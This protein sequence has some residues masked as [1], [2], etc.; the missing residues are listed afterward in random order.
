MIRIA[1]LGSWFKVQD[2]E[3]WFMVLCRAKRQSRA[4]DSGLMVGDKGR[5]F[6]EQNGG[7]TA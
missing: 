3:L 2:Y 4:K 5:D 7:D 6:E 1:I